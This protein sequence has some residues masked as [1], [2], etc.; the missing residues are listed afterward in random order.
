MDNLNFIK[1]KK[2]KEEDRILKKK[3]VFKYFYEILSL[4]FF[5]PNFYFCLRSSN[6]YLDKYFFNSN[7]NINQFF[8][9]SFLFF[10]FFKML[11]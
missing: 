10:L 11:Q 6:I 9:L 3:Y 5:R 2:I 1:I 7:E 4:N 8:K